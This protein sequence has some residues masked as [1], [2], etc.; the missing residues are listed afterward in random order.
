METAM[1]GLTALVILVGVIATVF[2][3]G[4]EV[5]RVFRPVGRLLDAAD[6]HA[7]VYSAEIKNTAI[8]KG[9]KIKVD[10][11]NVN[12]AK[13]NLDLINSFEI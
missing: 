1:S 4:K 5:A 13:E 7:T 2:W 9:A 6:T 3:Y 12:K 8:E 10:T 11:K